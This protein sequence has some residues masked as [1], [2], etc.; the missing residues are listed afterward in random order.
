MADFSKLKYFMAAEFNNPQ[1]M[2]QNLVNMLDSLRDK[3]GLPIKVNSSYRTPDHNAEVGGVADSSHMQ[4]NAV[5]VEVLP[6]N[7]VYDLVAIAFQLGFYG[8]GIN[9]K[10]G[11]PTGF[12][13]LEVRPYIDRA[14]WTY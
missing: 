12:V 9:K 2:N 3:L 6:G 11:T 5:D 7:F 13:H 8:I 14:I 1:A 10:T 4:G